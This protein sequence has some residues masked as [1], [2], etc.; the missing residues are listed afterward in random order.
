[1]T[2]QQ[3]TT[4]SEIVDYAA[5]PSEECVMCGERGYAIA[6]ETNEVLCFKCWLNNNEARRKK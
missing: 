2:K 1:M 3:T 6:S 5:S 4:D